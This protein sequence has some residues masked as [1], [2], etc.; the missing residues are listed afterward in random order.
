MMVYNVHIKGVASGADYSIDF[1]TYLQF[2]AASTQ[3]AAE[4]ARD[5]MERLEEAVPYIYSWE[6]T[7]VEG[8]YDG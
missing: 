6:I 1:E 3:S 2:E 8:A 7:S 5:N 4:Q